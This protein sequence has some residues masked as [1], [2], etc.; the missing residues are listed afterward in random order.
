MLDPGRKPGGPGW[1][2][3]CPGKG[4]PT[5]SH[6]PSCILFLS[7]HLLPQSST[8]KSRSSLSQGGAA[9]SPPPPNA[10]LIFQAAMQLKSNNIRFEIIAGI[11][12]GPA[13][14]P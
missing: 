1:V 12:I 7:L 4:R 3:T 14:F 13:C 6:C 2:I 5:S 8:S 10:R 11:G 9:K